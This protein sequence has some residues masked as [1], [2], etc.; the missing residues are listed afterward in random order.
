VVETVLVTPVGNAVLLTVLVKIE[1]L[2]PET[3]LLNVLLGDN[4]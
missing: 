2:V 4:E 1:L 3:V